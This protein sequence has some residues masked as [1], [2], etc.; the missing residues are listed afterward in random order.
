MN[1]TPSP[2]ICSCIKFEGTCRSVTDLGVLQIN[3][4]SV[5]FNLGTEAAAQTST[6][7]VTGPTTAASPLKKSKFGTYRMFFP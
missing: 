7:G 3:L 4:I 1:K 6:T 5:T 2:A